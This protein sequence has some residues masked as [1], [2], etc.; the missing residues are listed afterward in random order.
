MTSVFAEK[1]YT[2]PPGSPERKAILDVLRE[3]LKNPPEA[4]NPYFQYWRV[5]ADEKVIFLVDYFSVKGKWAWVEA[6][7]KNW[8]LNIYALLFKKD[9]VW[10]AKGM[11][12]PNIFQCPDPYECINIKE[13]IYKKFKE[14]FP[15][16]PPE[17]FPEQHPECKAILNALRD[18][19]KSVPPESII[20]IVRY[21]KVRNGWAWIETNPRGL[22]PPQNFEPIDALLHKEKDKW[23]VKNIR[24]CCGDCA[25]DPY[26]GQGIYHKKLM[27]MFPAVPKE[28]FPQ[29]TR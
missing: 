26:C 21:L 12:D 1:P 10:I 5:P 15:L 27:R 11:V 18:S 2:P 24:P 6:E 3:E 8:T 19:I 16:A 28:I 13:I 20:F 17:I 29:K 22:K 23:R 14:K 9:N 7:G 4:N 25:Y